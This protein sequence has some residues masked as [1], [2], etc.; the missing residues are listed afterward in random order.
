MFVLHFSQALIAIKFSSENIGDLANK[1]RS[2]YPDKNTVLAIGYSYDDLKFL[3]Q[4]NLSISTS[5]D[6]PTDIKVQNLNKIIQVLKIGPYL[7][8]VKLFKW[9]LI[10]YRTISISTVVFAYQTIMMWYHTTQTING[11]LVFIYAIINNLLQII[12][13]LYSFRNPTKL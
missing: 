3:G 12:Y 7:L 9:S 5:Q 13:N 10:L 1:I 6:L 4:S 8:M 11:H 2:S